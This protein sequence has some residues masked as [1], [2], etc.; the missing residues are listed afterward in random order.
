[1]SQ[2]VDKPS[3]SI[4]ERSG[5]ASSVDP[6]N[7][8]GTTKKVVLFGI[9]TLLGMSE[10]A[11]LYFRYNISQDVYTWGQCVYWGLAA[12]YLW[13][14]LSP[15]IG[16]LGRKITLTKANWVSF[17]LV[18]L[19]AAIV[20]SL[21]QLTLD[22]CIVHFGNLYLFPMARFEGQT[23]FDLIALYLRF[24]LQRGMLSYF[25]IATVMYTLQYY[26]RLR[27]EEIRRSRVENDLLTSQLD[28]L[29][30]QLQPHFLF[31]T[32]NT[33]AELIHT[34]QDLAD[35]VL[36]QLSK[37]LRLTLDS[38]KLI[39]VPL[40]D[41]LEFVDLYLDIHKARFEERLRVTRQIEPETLDLSVP[42]MITQPIVENAIKHGVS[43]SVEGAS[44]SISARIVEKRLV[45]KISDDGP[46]LGPDWDESS[47]DG[48]GL[49]N[50]QARLKQLYGDDHHFS[51][52]NA[53]EHGVE[54]LIAIPLRHSGRGSD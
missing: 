1:M 40:R 30:G 35:Q 13:G 38:G 53:V 49:E 7:L 8:S 45:L 2:L 31:N 41:E 14:I 3:H 24:M 44:I 4:N 11:R 16:W 10:A 52:K 37:M 15:A 42:T 47:I 6:L 19:A 48:I 12:W 54:V 46:G 50:T 32:L 33:I 43:A 23:L 27:A 22:A 17:L 18:H 34:D 9:W 39:E 5:S 25:L 26:R 21:V 36:T 28:A 29:R 20:L 51:I